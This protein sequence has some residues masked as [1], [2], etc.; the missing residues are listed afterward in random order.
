MT[1]C[2]SNSLRGWI[3]A[4]RRRDLPRDGLSSGTTSL[5]VREPGGGGGG[6][7]RLEEKTK[8]SV[9]VSKSAF[10]ARL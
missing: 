4:N 1:S 10:L 9:T 3:P 8:I 6:E 2:K 5:D 7:R